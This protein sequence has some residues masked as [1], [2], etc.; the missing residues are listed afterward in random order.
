MN[1]FFLGHTHRLISLTLF[2]L[3]LSYQ[4]L[5]AVNKP[6]I[7]III[8]NFANESKFSD[9]NWNLSIGFKELLIKELK[10]NKKYN[11][12][13]TKLLKDTETIKGYNLVEGKVIDFIMHEISGRIA[14]YAQ[15]D[16]YYSKIRVEFYLKRIGAEYQKKSEVNN[17]RRFNASKALEIE[18]ELYLYDNKSEEED[19]NNLVYDFRTRDKVIWGTEQFYKSTPGKLCKEV[20]EEMADKIEN[21][22]QEDSKLQ[23]NIIAIEPDGRII[24]NLGYQNNIFKGQK[25]DLYRTEV[26]ISQIAGSTNTV[27]EVTELKVGVIE[28]VDIQSN[29][30]SIAKLDSGDVKVN[31]VIKQ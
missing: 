9:K 18:D 17:E 27:T 24:A 20:V 7:N 29:N 11:I 23:G 10:Y 4:T 12:A 19:I 8:P 6:K 3:I 2:C 5:L 26:N 25:L 15:H 30:M 14:P 31:D 16:T 28:I 1:H 13:D 21:W 22:L